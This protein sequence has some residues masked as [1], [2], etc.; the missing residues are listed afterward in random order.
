MEDRR[1]VRTD[2]LSLKPHFLDFL[3]MSDIPAQ[4]LWSCHGN[5]MDGVGDEFIIWFNP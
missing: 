1:C 3:P 4:V 2:K 5:I